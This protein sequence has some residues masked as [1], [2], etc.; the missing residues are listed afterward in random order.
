MRTLTLATSIIALAAPAFADEV[1]I[2]SYRQPELIQPLLDGFTEKTGIETNVAFINK[3]LTERLKAEGERSPADIIL[4]VDISRL[5]EAKEAGV[6]QPVESDVLTNNI[7]AALRDSDNHWFGVTYRARIVY[8]SKDR[9]AEGAITTYEDL[10]DPKWKG[11]I[12]TRSGTHVY[13]LGLLSAVIEHDGAEAA[14]E[15][16]KG[17]KANLAKQPAGGDREQV[18]SIWAGE[19]DIAL[20]NTYY[21]GAMLKDPEQTQWANSVRIEFPTFEDG[22]GTHVNISGVAM[23]A[24][25]PN[26]D[27]AKAFMEYLASHEAQKIYADVVNEYPS[28]PETPPSDLVQSWGEITPDDTSLTD[29]AAHRAEALKIVERVDFDG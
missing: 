13:T 29:I 19:C 18:K 20:G 26:P 8:A 25:A 10:A 14:E 11:R 17:V 28:D 12:C 3:G 22:S 6:T 9:V 27:A 15:W 4:T 1:N 23:A 2:Y 16:L 21:M 7:P 5:S 24:S